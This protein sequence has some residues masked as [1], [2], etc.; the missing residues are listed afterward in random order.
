MDDLASSDVPHMMFYQLPKMKPVVCRR[1]GMPPL[2]IS[3]WIQGGY[4]HQWNQLLRC[5][6]ATLESRQSIIEALP[7]QSF[8]TS[9]RQFIFGGEKLHRTTNITPTP[10]V[11]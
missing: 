9:S 1:P 8:L 4:T 11:G 5:V 10:V 6:A 2:S 7:L 3:R